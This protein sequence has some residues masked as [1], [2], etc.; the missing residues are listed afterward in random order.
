MRDLVRHIFENDPF[1]NVSCG[2][3]LNTKT[4]VPLWML[5]SCFGRPSNYIR[6]QQSY[7][8]NGILSPRQQCQIC[9]NQKSMN[10][11]ITLGCNHRFCKDCMVGYIENKINE[12]KVRC[13]EMNCPLCNFEINSHT[14]QNCVSPKMY[15]TYLDLTIKKFRP[16]TPDEK[17]NWCQK[18][19]FAMTLNIKENFECPQCSGDSFLKF[20]DGKISKDSENLK[21]IKSK[22]KNR[23]KSKEESLK[24]PEDVIICPTCSNGCLKESGCNFIECKWPECESTFCNICR[25]PLRVTPK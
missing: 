2:V 22:S 1:A 18:C 3:C 13:D 24:L 21:P 11:F 9:Q 8:E 6:T 14:I 15:A 23:K 5:Q 7:I 12:F 16:Q 20:Q 25:T 10:H 19:G 4:I 17:M